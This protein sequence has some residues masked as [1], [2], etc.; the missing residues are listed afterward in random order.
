MSNPTRRIVLAGVA[1]TLALG[2]LVWF[3]ANVIAP[4]V[5]PAPAPLHL[6]LVP[7][8]PVAGPAPTP[9]A[10]VPSAAA[11]ELD[12]GAPEP[13]AARWHLRPDGAV[14]LPMEFRP[15]FP[16]SDNPTRSHP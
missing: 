7:I 1:G 8:P 11:D 12:R 16:L 3:A 9:A 6:R 5:L 4:A 14:E 15:A 2:P 10:P 13:I